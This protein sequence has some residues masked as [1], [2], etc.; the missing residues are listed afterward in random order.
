MDATEFAEDKT[1]D[2]SQLDVEAARQAETFF[3]WAERAVEAKG[4]ADRLKLRLDIL[5]SRLGIQCREKPDEFGLS[6]VTEMAIMAAIKTHE[7]YRKA[8]TRW[9]RAKEVAA[10]LDRAVDA[11][12]MKKRMLESLITLHGQQYFAGPSTP[13]DLVSAWKE[14]QEEIEKAVNARQVLRARRRGEKRSEG[15]G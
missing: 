3:K 6:R 14:K 12:D 1:I 11:M 10:L 15:D 4:I 8:Y 7:D 13:R 9:L 2:P 5:E